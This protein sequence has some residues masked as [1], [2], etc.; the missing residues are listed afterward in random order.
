MNHDQTLYAFDLCNAYA[1]PG[2][3][4]LVR[5]PRSGRH[6][7][8]T[9]DVYGA[10][11]GCRE[12]HT[13]DE[14]AARL[15]RLNPVLAGQE[16]A[17]LGVL[18]SVRED[19]LL[20]AA[21]VY[22]VTLQPANPPRFNVDKPVVAI[23]TWERP[24]A[25]ERCLDSV[26]QRVDPGNVARFV[27]IDDS[28]GAD[29]RQRNRAITQTFADV[30]D[31]PVLHLGAEEQRGFL[32]AIVRQVPAIEQQVRFL[33]DRD[34]WADQWTSGLARTLALLLSVGQRLIVLDDDILCDIYE[35]ERLPGVGF[36]EDERAT[37]FYTGQEDWQ[38]RPA[39]QGTDPV[40][41]HM[42]TLGSTLADALGALGV[43]NLAPGAFEGANLEILERWRADSKVLI[44]ECGAQGDAGTSN[45][46]WLAA[47]EGDSLERLIAGDDQVARAFE[48]R[49]CWHGQRQPQLVP[50]A[51][52]S[53]MTG[54]D[55]RGLMPP[56]APILRGEDRLFGDMVEFLHPD[57][58]V[59]DQPWAIAHLPLP[60]RG[61]HEDQQ[62]FDTRQPFERYAMEL[63][64]RQR[65][66]RAGGEPLRRLARLAR[67]YEE[68]ADRSVD[69]LQ[70]DYHDCRL[71]AMAEDYG[72]LAEARERAG[73]QAPAAWDQFLGEALERLNH[74]LV[75]NPE[76]VTITGIPE[77]LQGEALITWWQDYWRQFGHALR[78]W[79]AIR[80]A[81]RQ[82]QI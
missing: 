35:P 80:Q 51:N 28:R 82:V 59:L 74:E 53:Q 60:E 37:R 52:M 7:M 6:A 29:A 21:D 39:E 25:L 68:Q 18:E 36:R 62:H 31:A 44:T 30:V 70:A 43:R 55:N 10:L 41:R 19:G 1:L 78:A 45:L 42:R 27:V 33:I 48:H 13:L 9:P 22:A 67:L 32:E 34:R 64:E 77:D 16:A 46:N 79:P 4:M 50:R 5:N 24:E 76:A 73:A 17:V 12:F 40:L 15:A 61:W 2:G 71:A 3:R 20:I 11:L 47:L 75:V 54:I 49:S 58:V 14:H 69:D 56:Y 63:V 81:A 8:L 66:S 72:T 26:K 65:G 57:S 23:I 38:E